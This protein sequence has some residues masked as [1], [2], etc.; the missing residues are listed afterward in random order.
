MRSTT[1]LAQLQQQVGQRLQEA[2]TQAGLRQEDV[3][4]AAHI[5][6]KR[7]QAI[8][9]GRVNATLRTLSRVARAMGL[10]YWMLMRKP[11]GSSRS[12]VGDLRARPK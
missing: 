3:A 8:E 11:R 2:R 7:Y 12:G 4:H 9:E 10:D 6:Y 1:S 5:D